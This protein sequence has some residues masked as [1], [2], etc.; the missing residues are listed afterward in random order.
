ML[1]H[2]S[3]GIVIF[4][5]QKIILFSVE[6]ETEVDTEFSAEEGTETS[7]ASTKLGFCTF[8][9]NQMKSKNTLV[10]S[11]VVTYANLF[12]WPKTV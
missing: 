10:H 11:A 2:T 7:M 9:L 12:F 1:Q 5:Q 8:V 3:I 4:C 6:V